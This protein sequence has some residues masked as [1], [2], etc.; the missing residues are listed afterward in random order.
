MVL[1]QALVLELEQMMKEA[2]E[3]GLEEL[4]EEA[5]EKEEVGEKEGEREGTGKAEGEGEGEL[6]KEEEKDKENEVSPFKAPTLT[7]ELLHRNQDP[8]NKN[9]SL[10][11][12]CVK[13]N[14]MFMGFQPKYSTQGE[15]LGTHHRGQGRHQLVARV[16]E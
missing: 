6:E 4:T 15:R 16:P 8:Q 14:A 9:N 10:P 2:H 7:S 3:K 1:F 12:F 5:R 13:I 11:F